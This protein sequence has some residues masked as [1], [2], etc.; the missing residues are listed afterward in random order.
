VPVYNVKWYLYSLHV[1]YQHNRADAVNNNAND[2]SPS[3]TTKYVANAVG[4]IDIVETKQN[5]DWHEWHERNAEGTQG[6]H[7]TGIFYTVDIVFHL[8]RSAIFAIP[9]YLNK[10]QDSVGV[11]DQV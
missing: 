3:D 11:I 5:H 8:L 1:R 2:D 6:Q 4:R 9:T 10:R 7:D